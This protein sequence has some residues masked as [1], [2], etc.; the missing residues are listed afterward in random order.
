MHAKPILI[1]EDAAER[2]DRVLVCGSGDLRPPES[3]K[4]ARSTAPQEYQEPCLGLSM[5]RV[6][7]EVDA[8]DP[9]ASDD[10]TQ[11]IEGDEYRMPEALAEETAPRCSRSTGRRRVFH[12]VPRG[13]TNWEYSCPRRASRTYTRWTSRVFVRYS[14]RLAYV[15]C[16]RV[17]SALVNRL[18][19]FFFPLLVGSDSAWDHKSNFV[20]GSSRCAGCSDLALNPA[21]PKCCVRN[22][23]DESACI[24][25]RDNEF[26]QE[27]S[28][29]A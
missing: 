13:T 1:R 27:S 23:Y 25:A 24:T 22:G 21:E 10:E 6:A 28:A 18:L 29:R 26:C 16:D 12:A 5:E 9:C 8:E 11:L 4:A 14:L 17:T 3:E 2:Q 15:D 7:V 20:S 19:H